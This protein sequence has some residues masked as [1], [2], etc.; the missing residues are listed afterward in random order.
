[1][2]TSGCHLWWWQDDDDDDDETP[3]SKITGIL[4]NNKIEIGAKIRT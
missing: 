4:Q 2:V 1:M 3:L